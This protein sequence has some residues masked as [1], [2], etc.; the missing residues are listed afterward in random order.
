MKLDNDN[1]NNIDD[2]LHQKVKNDRNS[3][4]NIPQ[5]ISFCEIK[6]VEELCELIERWSDYHLP[7]EDADN[8][9]FSL[10]S[11]P[12]GWYWRGK[13][14]NDFDANIHPGRKP[15][16]NDRFGIDSNC[17]GIYGI[18]NITGV[19]Y[20]NLYCNGT[21][22]MGVLLM[23]D[24]AGAH[25]DKQLRRNPINDKPV[26]MNYELIGNDVCNPHP[27]MSHMTTPQEFYDNNM[28]IFQYFDVQK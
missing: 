12:R 15:D 28:K 9:T 27:R 10:I 4:P 14:C 20:E 17:N 13:D 19:S 26:W 6:G 16:N 21:S 7:P 1:D 23:G 3:H 8:D 11:E 25:L 24:S 22:E 2:L 18:D 5:L